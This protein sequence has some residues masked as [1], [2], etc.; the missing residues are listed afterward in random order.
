MNNQLAVHSTPCK[1]CPSEISEDEFLFVCAWR[2][3][4]VCRG[5]WNKLELRKNE[6]HTTAN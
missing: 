2:P 1:H 3:E 6:Q 5:L 4:K